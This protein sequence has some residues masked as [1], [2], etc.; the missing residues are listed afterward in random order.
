MGSALGVSDVAIP[1]DWNLGAVAEALTDPTLSYEGFERICEHLGD[2][3]AAVK[4][5]DAEV[6]P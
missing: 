6:K 5:A 1:T 4:W 2:L 3:Y